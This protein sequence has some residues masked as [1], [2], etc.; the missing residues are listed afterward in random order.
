MLATLIT[1]GSGAAST[2]TESGASRRSIRRATIACSSRSLA[3]WQELLAEVVVD[4]RVGAAAGGAGQRDGRG[5][6]AAAAHEQLR[7]GAHEGGL[8]GADAEA[9]AGAERL[10]QRAEQRRRRVR[11][12]GGDAHLAGEHELVDVD[13]L[14]SGARP[15]RPRPRSCVGGSAEATSTGRRR[16]PGPAAAAGRRAARRAGL[17]AGDLSA[18]GSSSPAADRA[19][20]SAGAA[21][22]MPGEQQLGH[23][24]AAPAAATTT[25][26]SR[27]SRAANAIPPTQ[28]GPAPGGRSPGSS[29]SRSRMIR[30]VSRRRSS[31]RPVPRETTSWALPIAPIASPS[32][33]GSSQQNQRSS[34]RREAK[35]VGAGIDRRRPPRSR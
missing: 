15:P 17:R 11:R 26:P 27:P 22:P 18:P 31:T 24:R 19:E 30:V 7:A 28:S 4:R 35:A 5:D 33:S 14:G 13:R 10:A 1:T 12:P 23:R 20:R 2:Q 8:G 34:A 25:A 32:R 6:A 21:R 29:A 9:E 16:G 3:L